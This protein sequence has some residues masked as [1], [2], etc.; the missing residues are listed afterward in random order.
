MILKL[1]YE[2]INITLFKPLK[3]IKINYDFCSF[4]YQKN[5]NF[6]KLE[7]LVK[8]VKFPNFFVEK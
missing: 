1:F 2:K 8:F 4:L 6:L 3:K 5:Y 7:K